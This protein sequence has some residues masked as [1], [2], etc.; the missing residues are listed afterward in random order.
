[1]SD[2][3]FRCQNGSS[4]GQKLSICCSCWEIILILF[5]SN[6]QQRMGPFVFCKGKENFCW[7]QSCISNVISNRNLYGEWVKPAM[8][9]TNAVEQKS[10]VSNTHRV[11]MPKNVH[12]YLCECTSCVPLFFKCNRFFKV[13]LKSKMCFVLFF[14]LLHLNVWTSL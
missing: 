12:K 14:Y 1:M 11:L 7:L 10:K 3:D 13:P 5:P 9:L 8:F 2:K 4:D 6:K